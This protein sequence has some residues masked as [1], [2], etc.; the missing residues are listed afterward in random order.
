MNHCVASYIKRVV[1]GE[2]LIYFLRKTE[3]IETSL[4]TVEV[5]NKA[6]VQAK[7]LHNRHINAKEHKALSEFAA[8]N[9]MA[10][11]I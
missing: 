11:R 9:K 6:I 4:V 8:R 3:E 2:C 5:R 7:G 10:V 1:D